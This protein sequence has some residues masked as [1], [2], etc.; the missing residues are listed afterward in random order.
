MATINV[1]NRWFLFD[2]KIL[3]D[4]FPHKI[5]FGYKIDDTFTFL[6]FYF[7]TKEFSFR[8]GFGKKNKTG[9]PNWF[10]DSMWEGKWK[11]IG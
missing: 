7:R 11:N 9:D 1:K 2:S 6:S 10:K 3:I 4:Y 8:D 5:S